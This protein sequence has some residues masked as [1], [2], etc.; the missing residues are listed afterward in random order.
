LYPFDKDAVHTPATAIH[1]DFAI[2]GLQDARN[3]HACELAGLVG[4]E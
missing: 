4:V 2:A 1:A 3:R